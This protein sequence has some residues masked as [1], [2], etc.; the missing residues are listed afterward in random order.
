M[1]GRDRGE[2]EGCFAGR[3]VVGKDKAL[4]IHGFHVGLGKQFPALGA[5]GKVGGDFGGGG[6]HNPPQ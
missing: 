1:E 4:V 6:W 5:I 2:N 3:A